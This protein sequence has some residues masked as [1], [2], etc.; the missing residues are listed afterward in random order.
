MESHIIELKG[1][2]SVEFFR[3]LASEVRLTILEI[4]QQRPMGVSALAEALGLSPPSVTRHIKDM[5]TVGLITT[6]PGQGDQAMQKVC[7][8]ASDRFIVSFENAQAYQDRVVEIETPVGM[9]SLA[10]PVAPCGLAAAEA[11]IG[12]PD[13]PQSFFLPDRAAAKLLW[14]ADGYVE[15]VF[16][17]RVPAMAEITRLELSLEICSEARDYDNDYP[18]DITLWINEVEIGTWTSPGDFGGKRGRLNPPWWSDNRTQFGMLKVWSVDRESSYVDGSVLSDCTLGDLM[19]V[20][21][22]PIVVRIGNK[23]DARHI[24]GIN[25]LGQSFGNYRQDIVLRL[26]YPE[27]PGEHP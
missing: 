14:M 8:P 10:A 23:P 18:S 21:Q 9:Y 25:I 24:G 12:Y 15:Y 19:L 7:R 4:L 1:Q 5:E 3:A 20:P 17:C 22:A 27:R 13:D 11:L 6:G 16:P 2:D 26:H